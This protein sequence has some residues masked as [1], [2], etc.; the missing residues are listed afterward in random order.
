M[1]EKNIQENL[2]NEF[3]NISDIDYESVKESEFFQK[4]KLLLDLLE[5][6]YFKSL[7][8]KT[9]VTQRFIAEKD[10]STRLTHTY[11]VVELSSIISDIRGVDSTRAT[12]IA[13]FHDVGHT[14]FGHIGE[15]TIERIIENVLERLTI[16]GDRI[17]YG[18]DKK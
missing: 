5:T 8:E 9:Q 11:Q 13:A 6:P 2:K 17:G 1:C 15:R 16:F 18:Y 3:F 14:P 10:V 4:D 7:D 12:R